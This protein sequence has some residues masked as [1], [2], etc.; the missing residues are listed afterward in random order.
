MVRYRNV[1][2]RKSAKVSNFLYKG[3][4]SKYFKLFR[5]HSLCC[6][7][8][9]LPLQCS[10]WLCSMKT[11]FTKTGD[12]LDLARSHMLCQLLPFC[13][14]TIQNQPLTD[15]AYLLRGFFAQFFFSSYLFIF[16][17]KNSITFHILRCNCY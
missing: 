3:L 17:L 12:G 5:P 11:L 6:N 1:Q 15:L 13:V 9:P 8:L 2:R 10:R 14:P 7:P 4:D 16:F